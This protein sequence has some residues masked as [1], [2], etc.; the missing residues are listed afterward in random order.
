MS[1]LGNSYLNGIFL[2]LFKWDYDVKDCQKKTFS[3]TK[4]C[5]K[6]FS[7]TSIKI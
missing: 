6:F 4:D 7:E 3:S 5:M 1:Y 2:I